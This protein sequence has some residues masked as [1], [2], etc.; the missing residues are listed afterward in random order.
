MNSET[1][2]QTENQDQVLLKQGGNEVEDEGS[3][4]S[5]VRPP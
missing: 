1:E 2:D 3:G 5:L 4:G